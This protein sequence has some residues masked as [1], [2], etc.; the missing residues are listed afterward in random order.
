MAGNSPEGVQ[1]GSSLLPIGDRH[2]KGG[3]PTLYSDGVS[4]AQVGRE[5]V[6]FYLSRFDPNMSGNGPAQNEPVAQIVMSAS[7]FAQT[8][9]FLNAMV[10]RMI[11]AGV[12]TVEEK[13]RFFE[14]EVAG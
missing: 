1:G 11:I 2:P 3:I 13:A 8:A 9:G 4:S 12:I 14:L 6:R 10:D 7:A 5:V